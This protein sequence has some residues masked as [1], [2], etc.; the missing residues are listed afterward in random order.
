MSIPLT[1]ATLLPIMEDVLR[2]LKFLHSRNIL[3]RDL[4]VRTGLGREPLLSY[5]RLA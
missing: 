2:G 1:L 3:H 5:L 4:K